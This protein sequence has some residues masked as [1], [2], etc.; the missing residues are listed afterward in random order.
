M[1]AKVNRSC[2]VIVIVAIFAVTGC[3]S[4]STAKIAARFGAA[5]AQAAEPIGHIGTGK[6]AEAVEK[7]GSSDKYV[8]ALFYK[9]N[10]DQLTKARSLVESAR[11]KVERKSETVEINVADPNEQDIVNKFGTSRA[12]MPLVLVLA[13]NGAIMGGFPLTQL[14]DETRL[15][16]CVG[17][18]AS[19]QTLKALQQKNMVV[20]CA[21][22]KTTAENGRAMRGVEEFL[23]DPKYGKTTAVVI[24]DPTEPATAKFI[25]Q[26]GLDPKSPMAATAILAPPGSVIS[27]F[28]GETHADKIISAIKAAAAPKGCGPGG[29]GGKP[30]G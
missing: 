11:K 6:C 17:C 19:E 7:A 2:I 24:V 21:Q 22:S 25:T 14:P 5:S 28:Q 13:P 1:R 16:E 26:L 8:Y 9:E 10:N 4:D 3:S 15:V 23:R 18:K 12:P 29:C 27:T 20:L 30:C